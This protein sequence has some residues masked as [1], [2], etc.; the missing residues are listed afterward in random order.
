MI[1]EAIVAIAY[2][3]AEAITSLLP[4]VDVEGN[5]VYLA[6]YVYPAYKTLL[7]IPLIGTVLE[8]VAW[9]IV[10]EIWLFVYHNIVAL[11]RAI[12]VLGADPLPQ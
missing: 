9:Y 6:N 3:I 1:T 8:I 7:A 10:F 12:H 5:N 4:S 11:L 2:S